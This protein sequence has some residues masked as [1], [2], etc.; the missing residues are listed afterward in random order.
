M[1]LCQGYRGS[2]PGEHRPR[3]STGWTEGGERA[4]SSM[5]ASK[6]EREERQKSSERKSYQQT[7]R[8]RVGEEKLDRVRERPKGHMK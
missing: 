6:R 3:Q 4:R 8:G 1:P 7:H 2:R 5:G